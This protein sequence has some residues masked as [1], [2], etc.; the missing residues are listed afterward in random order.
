MII[1]IP[2]EIKPQEYRVG[3]TP[4]G[5]AELVALGHNVIC[6]LG[7]GLGSCFA[8]SEYEEAGAIMSHRDEVFHRAELIVKVKEPL[9]EEF[10]LLRHGLALFTY[11]HLAPNRPLAMELANRG[12]SA[13]AYETL[14]ADGMLALLKPMSEIAGRMAPMMGAYFLQ[15]P[16]GGR[17]VL[18]T[19]A[20]TVP[21]AKA[22]ILGAGTVGANAA[23]VAHSMGMDI[24]L[25]DRDAQRLEQIRQN[26][27]RRMHT[28][29]SS[30]DNVATS[31]AEADLVIGAV[32]LPGARAPRIVTRA[33]LKE[34]MYGMVVVDV[35]ID[36][37]GCFETSRPTT[38]ADPVYTVDDVLHYCV[39]NMPGAYP[40]TSTLA[41]TN[42][43]LPYIIRLAGM[44]AEAA[45]AGD[46]QQL[47]SALN[48]HKGQIVH[49]A[50]KEALS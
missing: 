32:L 41:L 25:I 35:S 30:E 18:P 21:A 26:Y 48:I 42:A 38:H 19:G 28:L 20:S 39:A 2:K 50:L 22:V 49:P 11:L 15:R 6:E 24:T 37:G 13:F 12:V 5:A 1:G 14:E 34:L 9:P 33:M 10:P 3:L 31:I 47:L 7:L 43:T 27:A 44:G 4:E 8:D 29:E 45:A 40:R 36:Q 16:M 46:D 17:G 23:H